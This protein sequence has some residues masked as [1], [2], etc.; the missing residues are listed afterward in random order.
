VTRPHAPA[1]STLPI[2]PPAIP[3]WRSD[4]GEVSPVIAAL[5]AFL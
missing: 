3:P 5:L 4:L 1:K 2:G